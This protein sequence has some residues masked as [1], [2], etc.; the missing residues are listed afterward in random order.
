MTSPIITW[1]LTLISG[2]V[3]GNIGGALIKE[4]SLGQIGN[5]GVSG[6]VGALLPI[7]IGIL[8]NQ[9]AKA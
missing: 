9:F 5:I 7:I 1:L 4:Q 8:K 2:A 6:V 3:G